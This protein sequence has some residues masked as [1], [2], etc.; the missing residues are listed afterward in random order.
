MLISDMSFELWEYVI[1]FDKFG[2][3]DITKSNMPISIDRIRGL[4]P[5]WV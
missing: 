1:I 5:V 3:T 2:K 4:A